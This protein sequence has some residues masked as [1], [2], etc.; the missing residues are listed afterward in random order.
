MG[1]T[2]EYQNINT[3]K[4]SVCQIDK[5]HAYAYDTNMYPVFALNLALIN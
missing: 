1:K 5:T 3:H 2:E 4:I